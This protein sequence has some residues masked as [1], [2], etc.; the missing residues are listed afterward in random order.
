M[1]GFTPIVLDVMYVFPVLSE[2]Q[3]R[4]WVD[5][6]MWANFVIGLPMRAEW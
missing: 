4:L 5:R 3:E 2:M 1:R 6:R